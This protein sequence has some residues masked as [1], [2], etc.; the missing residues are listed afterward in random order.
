MI[1]FPETDKNLD[2]EALA[3]RGRMLNGAARLK[4]FAD[5]V[6][7]SERQVQNWLAEGMPH[8]RIG[9]TPW[10]LV[11]EAKVWLISRSA[12]AAPL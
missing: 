2:C 5:A 3:I 9:K 6:D 10:I 1:N 7:K 8:I 12:T 11:D 4:P